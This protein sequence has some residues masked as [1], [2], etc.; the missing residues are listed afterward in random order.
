LVVHLP[1]SAFIFGGFP[2]FSIVFELQFFFSSGGLSAGGFF[3]RFPPFS[4]AFKLQSFK[5]V[6]LVCQLGGVGG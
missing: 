3:G 1:G 4:I 2:P 5:L 6:W